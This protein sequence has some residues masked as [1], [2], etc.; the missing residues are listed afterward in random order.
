M[1]SERA[2]L[3]QIAQAWTV[4]HESD[5]DECAQCARPTF[6]TARAIARGG[7]CPLCKAAR[8]GRKWRR[9]RAFI[10]HMRRARA[11]GEAS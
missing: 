5:G 2:A 1:L 10:T 7:L 3:A 4:G 8:A 9:G 6:A 11:A